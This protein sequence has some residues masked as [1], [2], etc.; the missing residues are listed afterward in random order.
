MFI[1]NHCWNVHLFKDEAIL[2][3]LIR[4]SSDSNLRFNDD[5]DA[6]RQIFTKWR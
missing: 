6:K 1:N 2:W 5:V 4:D 3:R